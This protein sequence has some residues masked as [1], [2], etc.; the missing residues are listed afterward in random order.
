MIDSTYIPSHNLESGSD[1]IQVRKIEHKNH[2]DFT[3]QHRH[4]YFEIMCFEKGGGKNL[5]DFTEYTVSDHSCCIIYPEQIHLLKRAPGSHGFVIQFQRTSIVSELLQQQLQIRMWSTKNAI[6]F[7]KNETL[8]NQTMVILDLLQKY[9]KSGSGFSYNSQQHLLHTLLFDLF[10]IPQPNHQSYD[11]IPDFHHFL[12]LIDQHF[13][14]H[15]NVSFYTGKLK[16][17]EKKL[18]TLTKKHQGMSPLQ[19]IH[20]RILLEAKRLLLA[21][22]LPH[23]Q[24]AYDLGFDSP[25]SFSAFIKKKTGITASEIQA[26]WR[27]FT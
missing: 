9:T 2:Y 25:S 20:Q 7:E 18:A 19:I 14:I 13:N 23:K 12:Q 5:I 3:K 6:V 27:K 15:Q 21:G 8:F 1:P 26:K 24:I 4:T 11:L 10:S 22:K 17:S 16:I